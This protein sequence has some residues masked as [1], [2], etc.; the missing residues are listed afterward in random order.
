MLRCQLGARF[1]NFFRK[2]EE[3]FVKRVRVSSTLKE[4]GFQGEGGKVKFSQVRRKHERL[5][6]RR[7]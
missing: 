5:S 1:A 2:G 6:G 3:H 7:L 4:D